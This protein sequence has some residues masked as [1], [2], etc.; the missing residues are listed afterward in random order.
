MKQASRFSRTKQFVRIAASLSAVLVFGLV[1]CTDR[2][3]P[4]AP[5]PLTSPMTSSMDIAGEGCYGHDVV[6]DWSADAWRD[7]TVSP[8]RY[9][10]QDPYWDCPNPQEM[11]GPDWGNDYGDGNGFLFWGFGDEIGEDI[12]DIVDQA[13]TDCPW[14]ALE[15]LAEQVAES[16][17]VQQHAQEIGEAIEGL[18]VRAVVAWELF[19]PSVQ[20][21][22]HHIMTDKNWVAGAQ[23][24]Q[25][26]QNL[27]NRVGMQ[28]S[29]AA[30][31]VLVWDHVGP[32]P[33]EYHQYVWDRILA[34]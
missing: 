7:N 3:L 2:V 26:F 22:W 32:H 18:A 10:D 9:Y 6:W 17:A 19:G 23:W 20:A 33:Q 29:D 12:F 21:Q 8:T 30:N 25:R 11:R 24:S 34:D 27:L 14:C 13:A 5:Q 15:Q 31:Q 16:P 1:A 28:L 4:T